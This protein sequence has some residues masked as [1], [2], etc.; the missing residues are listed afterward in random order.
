MKCEKCGMS[1]H[2]KKCEM[3]VSHSS[4][5]TILLDLRLIV[6]ERVGSQVPAGCSARPGAGVVRSKSKKTGGGGGTDS[7]PPMSSQMSNLSLA[8]SASSGTS[9]SFFSASHAQLR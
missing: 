3:K 7:S 4:F 5:L 1:V 9:S 8:R 2:S 6:S